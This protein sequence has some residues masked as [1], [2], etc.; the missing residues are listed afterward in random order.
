MFQ[1]DE[2]KLVTLPFS[3]LVVDNLSVRVDMECLRHGAGTSVYVLQL[4]VVGCI[5][6][7]QTCETYQTV[8]QAN[9][10]K[11]T[12]RRLMAL[13]NCQGIFV[14]PRTSTPVSS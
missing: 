3:Q 14:A 2:R 7:S 4:P 13:S 1:V 9:E 12:D 11:L 6:V 8:L 5:F 10:F